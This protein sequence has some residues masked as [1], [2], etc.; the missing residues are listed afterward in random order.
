ME[1]SRTVTG[2]GTSQSHS[3]DLQVGDLRVELGIASVS[4]DGQPLA[5]SKLS[6]DL[7]LA[8]ARA[9]PNLVT[10]DELMQQVW[11]RVVVEADTVSQRVK[12]LR[13]ALGD[14]AHEPR[15][16]AG[17]R[18][19]GY[20]LIAP[21][22]PAAPNPAPPVVTPVTA[23]AIDLPTR[24]KRWYV[25]HRLLAIVM[26]SLV[27]VGAVAYSQSWQGTVTGARNSNASVR[28]AVL[29]LDV[30]GDGI[31]T[32]YLADGISTSIANQLVAGGAT[33]VAPSVS[34]SYRG[35]RKARALSELQASYIV[36]GSVQRRGDQLH[37]SMHAD[38]TQQQVIVWSETFDVTVEGANRLPERIA[39][40]V[41]D[42]VSGASS[43]WDGRGDNDPGVAAAM[44][45]VMTRKRDGDEL[46]AY[47]QA[48]TQAEKTPDVAIAQVG[49]AIESAAALPLIAP[50]ER[51]AALAAARIA[52]DRAFALDS[53]YGAVA[54]QVVVPPVEWQQRE[55]ILR[56][57]VL[58]DP[59]NPHTQSYLAALLAASGRN[60]E[61]IPTC[62]Q[63]I[64]SDPL[65]SM[66]VG[67]CAVV[68][69]GAGRSDEAE[70]LLA[71]ASRLWPT[72]PYVAAARFSTLISKGEL[73][74]VQGWM[75]D[76]D[77]PLLRDAAARRVLPTIMRARLSRGSAD[78]AAM[79]S[80]CAE[81]AGPPTWIAD[82]C[83]RA[84]VAFDRMD[85]A[86]AFVNARTPEQRGATRAERDQRW[87]ENI[88][89]SMRSR[90]LFREDLQALRADAR[91]IPIVER[92]GLVDYWR[93]RNHWPDF[94]AAEPQSVC[95][96][97]R[98]K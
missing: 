79:E 72:S 13:H 23:A 66:K 80:A 86:F 9:A 94:C 91:F 40:L 70:M 20:R 83:L 35:E 75:R 1:P 32:Q 38:N 78:V 57:G 34:A 6:F 28:I 41:A 89:T 56:D 44:N 15:Y 21:V 16:I 17:V 93:N 84:L 90:V 77:T 69:D 45:R 11:P 3:H 42:A 14:D 96:Q 50:A 25:Q 98:V 46:G 12:L 65:S 92:L 54:Y 36:D 51:V 49:L 43:H 97:L 59:R 27:V 33:V 52:A 10:L 73:E 37:V 4:R 7:L 82:E 58:A 29:P 68:L 87:L 71:R 31:D 81:L 53:A 88:E 26:V 22:S 60:A 85:S 76:P 55:Q 47:I 18:G 64:T 19:R 63:S 2:T 48:R 67:S 61:S 62:Q 39:V 30:V 24:S 95:A 5:L 74:T 8:L